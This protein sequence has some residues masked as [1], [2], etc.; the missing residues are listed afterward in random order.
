MRHLSRAFKR[1]MPLVTYDEFFGRITYQRMKNGKSY[2]ECSRVFAPSGESIQLSVD[3]PGDAQR[4]DEKQRELYSWVERN[5]DATFTR[6]EPLLRS[7]FEESKGEP[8]LEPVASVFKAG[9]FSIPRQGDTVPE[10]EMDF[11]TKADAYQLYSVEMLGAEAR[12]IVDES[13]C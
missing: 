3:A 8:L 2:W 5:W 13:A 4:P 10:W 1:F 7:Q 12:S 6:A 11:E 9:G